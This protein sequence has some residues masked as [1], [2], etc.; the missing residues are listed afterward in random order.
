M[1]HLASYVVLNAVRANRVAGRESHR[2]FG[3]H[4]S[5]ALRNSRMCSVRTGLPLL[6]VASVKVVAARR[7]ASR[8]SLTPLRSSSTCSRLMTVSAGVIVCVSI[9]VIDFNHP[10]Q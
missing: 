1:Q 5:T 6:R 2:S 3:F 9:P 4:Y 7:S 10:I 8:A